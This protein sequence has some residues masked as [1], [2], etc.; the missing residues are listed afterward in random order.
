MD[1][2]AWLYTN[3]PSWPESAKARCIAWIIDPFVRRQSAE[4]NRIACVS[5]SVSNPLPIGN[6]MSTGC[7]LVVISK[8]S[9]YSWWR[10]SV[11]HQWSHDNVRSCI[12]GRSVTTRTIF[13]VLD[14]IL[15]RYISQGIDLHT[16][17]KCSHIHLM[18]GIKYYLQ[19]DSAANE[20]L[21]MQCVC[22][23]GSY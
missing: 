21:W 22:V 11:T 3:R 17:Y 12:N 5:V 14:P 8:D 6:W 2:P 23:T 4:V 18:A 16:I 19:Q 13:F 7:L 10:P 1:Q 9:P 20:S 15:D